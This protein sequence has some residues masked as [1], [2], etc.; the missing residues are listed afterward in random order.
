M[1]ERDLRKQQALQADPRTIKEINFTENLDR[2]EGAFMFFIL[3]EAKKS[4]LVFSQ[5]TVRV[6]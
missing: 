1:I 3:K 2:K 4:I 6:L 5:G